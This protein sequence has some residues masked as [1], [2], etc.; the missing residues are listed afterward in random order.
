MHC[1]ARTNILNDTLDFDHQ[2]ALVKFKTPVT[3]ATCRTTVLKVLRNAMPEFDA[4]SLDFDFVFGQEVRPE[5]AKVP[6]EPIAG[7]ERGG[8]EQR[9]L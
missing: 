5:S 6:A 2:K 8:G 4:G 7:E 9:R 1:L 3:G